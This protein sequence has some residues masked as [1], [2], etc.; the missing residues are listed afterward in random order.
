MKSYKLCSCWLVRYWGTWDD[1]LFCLGLGKKMCKNV[2]T[3]RKMIAQSNTNK[4]ARA[5]TFGKPVLP[6]VYIITAV[7][8]EAGNSAS[9][10]FSL[11]SSS[12]SLN[13]VIVQLLLAWINEGWDGISSMHM[14][15]FTVSSCPLISRSFFNSP[16]PQITVVTSVWNGRNNE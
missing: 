5:L 15:C 2:D 6:L 13:D 8:A 7:S 4:E 16:F 3:Q 10:G 9:T 1:F 11:P 14:T 12:I